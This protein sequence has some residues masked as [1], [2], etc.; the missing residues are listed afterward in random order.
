LAKTWEKTFVGRILFAGEDGHWF[1]V[2]GS[3]CQPPDTDLVRSPRTR[4]S[5][6]CEPEPGTPLPES[7]EYIRGSWTGSSPV[8]AVK[9]TASVLYLW[10][11]LDMLD[12]W[13]MPGSL[14]DRLKITCTGSDPGPEE[15]FPSGVGLQGSDTGPSDSVAMDSSSLAAATLDLTGVIGKYWY[16]C[17]LKF[18]DSW[19]DIS[20]IW[21]DIFEILDISTACTIPNDPCYNLRRF[22]SHF[23][24]TPSLSAK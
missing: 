21:L 23:V 3:H 22:T 14:E 19:P 5:V 6:A 7:S 10:C 18:V 4:W 17:R 13:G 20:I 8:S 16:P 12:S 11:L 9:V 1:L 2:F 15:S 24:R